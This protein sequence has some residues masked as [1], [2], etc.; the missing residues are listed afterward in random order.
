MAR[1]NTVLQGTEQCC[2]VWHR[3]IL[4][5]KAPNNAALQ[6]TE[7]C[8]EYWH[9]ECTLRYTWAAQKLVERVLDRAGMIHRG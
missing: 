3:T 8:S 9:V 1:N 7:Q 5:R 2:N 4:Y 6:G